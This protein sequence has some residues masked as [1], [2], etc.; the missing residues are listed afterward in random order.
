MIDAAVAAEVWGPLARVPTRTLSELGIGSQA[1]YVL[2]ELGLPI[3]AEPQFAPVPAEPM[4]A[5]DLSGR[6]VRFGTDAGSSLCLVP[7]DGAVI[8]VPATSDL[9][10]R[11]VN[12]DLGSFASFLLEVCRI[13]R[14][15]PA[16]DDAQID[17]ALDDLEERLR[18]MDETAFAD[19][20]HWWSV[21]FE[22]L[23]DGL[24]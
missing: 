9:Q 5:S 2:G 16:L 11:Y 24:L 10:Q 4:T 13:R 6:L 7:P 15:F 17:T 14:Q 21:I 18:S 3:A 12:A 22:Q 19:P 23:R 1:A 8:S 20:E